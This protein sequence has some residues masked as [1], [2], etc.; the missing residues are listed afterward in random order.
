MVLWFSCFETIEETEIIRRVVKKVSNDKQLSK[1]RISTDYITKCVKEEL[2]RMG[3]VK[4]MSYARLWMR[5]SEHR[6][7]RLGMSRLYWIQI[8]YGEDSEL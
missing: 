4:S 5:N 2:H 1:T 7:Y 3:G 8:L 6:L